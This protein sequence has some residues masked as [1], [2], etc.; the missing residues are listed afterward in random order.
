[1]PIDFLSS[2]VNSFD[3]LEYRPGLAD[4]DV[5][6]PAWFLGKWQGSS[7]FTEFVYPLGEEAHQGPSRN[8]TEKELNSV[9]E[10]PCKFKPDRY[11]SAKDFCIADRLYNVEQIALSSIGANSILDDLQTSTNPANELR[12]LI[13]PPQVLNTVYD[14]TLRTSD[15]AFA[16]VSNNVFDVMER[17][18]Q[19]ILVQSEFQ[20][21]TLIKDIETV[22]SYKLVDAN[23]IV[24]QQRTA[25]FLT[26]Q[27]SRYAKAAA[28]NPAVENTS[29]DVRKFTVKYSRLA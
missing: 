14:I 22:T 12:L 1:M 18:Q 10:Y 28:K 2:R 4:N 9:L 16:Y 5:Y 23:C 13:R 20:S 17:T 24:A 7:K 26:P 21:K 19:T 3:A 27:D 11:L 25:T 29:I 15:R 6:Y 8:T